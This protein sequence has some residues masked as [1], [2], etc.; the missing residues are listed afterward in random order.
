MGG[1][2][3]AGERHS[4]NCAVAV[5][6]SCARAWPLKSESNRRVSCCIC[7]SM[8]QRCIEL[9]FA[10]ARDERRVAS[11]LWSSRSSRVLL[12]GGSCVLAAA[13]EPASPGVGVCGAVMGDAHRLGAGIEN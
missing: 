7:C 9:G 2:I 5:V 1:C 6:S 8:C 11:S 10:L 13:S 3:V 12:L 4:S